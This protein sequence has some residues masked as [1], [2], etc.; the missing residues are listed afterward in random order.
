MLAWDQT[1]TVLLDMDGTLLDLHFD[2][3]FWQ[4]HLPRRYAECRGLPPDTAREELMARYR[5]VEGTLDWYCV[6]YW[7]REL[8]LDIAEL[9]E[10]VDHLIAVH[11]QAHDFLESARAHGK[12]LWLATNAHR[13]AL[14][15]KLDRTGIGALF[16]KIVSSHDLGAPKE[17]LLFWER[18]H[19]EHRFNPRTTV[20]IDDSLPV[21]R[22]AH[23]FGIAQVIAITRPDSTRPEKDVNGFPSVA[24]L[25][26]L[27]PR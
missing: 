21:L 24:R 5:R 8:V 19:A 16:D 9:K 15:L 10:E 25:G 12:K 3:H 2:N 17:T 1:E 27:I 11:D 14:A 6:D 18:L 20:L 23:A 13:K 22:A 4:E 26:D 7:S